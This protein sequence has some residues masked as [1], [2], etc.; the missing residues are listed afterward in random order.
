MCSQR[1]RLARVAALKL[2]PPPTKAAMA[3]ASTKPRMRGHFTDVNGFMHYPLIWSVGS[4]GPLAGGEAPLRGS[5]TAADWKNRGAT[6]I[7]QRV[8]RLA[9]R[10]PESHGRLGGR[11]GRQRL[12]S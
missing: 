10:P 12:L 4:G 6:P 5:C 11:A 2:N 1:V 9:S 7:I 3:M 8:P